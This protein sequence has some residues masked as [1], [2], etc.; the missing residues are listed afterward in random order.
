MNHNKV[1]QCS[2]AAR[3]T[4]TSDPADMDVGSDLE[5]REDSTLEKL[6]PISSRKLKAMTTACRETL[7]VLMKLG[8][9]MLGSMDKCL[10][11]L[12]EHNFLDNKLI[13][14]ETLIE[15]IRLALE[16]NKASEEVVLGKEMSFSKIISNSILKTPKS[17]K[18][19]GILNSAS[20]PKIRSAL[21]VSNYLLCG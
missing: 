15:L 5:T 11:I 12:K 20:S 7:D 13:S 21:Q 1:P 18:G 16:T 6:K 17:S 19:K 14:V 8:S 9:D 2:P 10:R 3:K 4:T